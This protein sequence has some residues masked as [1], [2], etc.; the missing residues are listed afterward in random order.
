MLT[1][2]EREW[3]KRRQFFNG[4]YSGGCLTCSLN[5]T[6]CDKADCPLHP[7]LEDALEFSERIAVKLADLVKYSVRVCHHSC[8]DC[9]LCKTDK[10]HDDDPGNLTCEG[11]ILK[12]ARLAVEEEMNAD[13]K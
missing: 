8:A 10:C 9:F 13:R 2:S 12:Y 6:L 1:N 5:R 11:T 3:L 7:D 4:F